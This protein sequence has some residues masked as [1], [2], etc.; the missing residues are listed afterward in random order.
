MRWE[1]KV[2]EYEQNSIGL[3]FDKYDAGENGRV[4]V[5]EWVSE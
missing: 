3:D 5:T 2:R 4:W 1:E